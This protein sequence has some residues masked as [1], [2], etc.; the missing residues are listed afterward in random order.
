MAWHFIFSPTSSAEPSTCSLHL[1]AIPVQ[2][3]PINA[4]QVAAA[5]IGLVDFGARVLSDTVE[6]YKSAS[7]H[8]QRDVELTTLS[9]EL[10]NLSEQLQNRLEG[11]STTSLASESTLRGLSARSIDASNK[12]KSAIADLQANK[13]GT[14]KISTAANSF[15]SALKAIWKKS[16]IE[17]LKENLVEIRSQITIATLI[18][19]WYVATFNTT[20]FSSLTRY[21]GKRR[22]KMARGMAT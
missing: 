7:G 9:D 3:D 11:T 14:S 18:S 1:W 8:T 12:L 10:S 13:P 15:A 17:A 6:I 16:E 5:V 2:M 19:V 20:S 22:D 21:S 4:F